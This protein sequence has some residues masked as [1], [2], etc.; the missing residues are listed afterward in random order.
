VGVIHFERVSQFSEST[1]TL[2]LLDHKRKDMLLYI[3]L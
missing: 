2:I 1:S 3:T